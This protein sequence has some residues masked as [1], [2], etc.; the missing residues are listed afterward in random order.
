MSEANTRA[1]GSSGDPMPDEG[2]LAPHVTRA[3]A[4]S[5][6]SAERLR[7]VG[8]D[9]TSGDFYPRYGHPAARHFEAA[10]ARLEGA[11]GAVSFASGMAALFGIF[12]CVLRQGDTVAV[13]RQVYGG[14][15]A[16]LMH[17][18][19]RFGVEVRRFDASDEEDI[20]RALATPVRL[21]HVETPTN[22]LCRVVDLTRIREY[23]DSCGAL[24]S[25]DATFLPPPLQRPIDHGADFVMH[26]ATKIIGGHS[27]ALGGIVSGRHELLEKLEAFRRRIGAILGPDTAWLYLRSLET[28]TLRARQ[29]SSNALQLAE[30]L[31]DLRMQDKGITEV[32]YPGLTRHPDHD[33]ALQCME[34]FGF[35]VTFGVAGELPDAIR[36]YDRFRK[37]AR[38]VSLGG[39]HTVASLPLHTSHSG[40]SIDARRRAG[41]GDT[42]IRISVGVEPVQSLE[43]DILA[44]LQIGL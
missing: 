44:A 38:A 3:T 39:V 37:I 28:L 11:D 18:L 16:M 24:L 4:F 17:D 13:S 34:T 2:P 43:Q 21:V 29:A 30:F 23:A 9:E 36:V 20:A 8:A 35:V 1:Y 6:A 25:V 12:A 7:S 10:V 5:Y 41:V 31:D 32:H 33:R 14:M 42:L 19:P 22:P 26:S 15:D 27:D 40:M